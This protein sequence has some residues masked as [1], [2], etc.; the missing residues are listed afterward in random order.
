MPYLLDTCTLF[1]LSSEPERLSDKARIAI[2]DNPGDLFAS[3]ISAFEFGIKERKGV[4]RFPSETETWFRCLLKELGLAQVPI[5]FQ[6]ATKS[7]QLPPLH[8][9]P[10][11]RIIIATAQEYSMQ[12]L[13]PDKLIQQYPDV[14]CRW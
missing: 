3:A 6:I 1:W 11:D 5:N 14:I 4:F 12:I 10:C 8:A 9:D 2:E 7:T 13:T